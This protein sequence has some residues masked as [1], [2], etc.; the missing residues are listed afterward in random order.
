MAPRE[1]MDD[2]MDDSEPIPGAVPLPASEPAFSFTVE[3]PPNVPPIAHAAIPNHDSENNCPS[4]NNSQPSVDPPAGGNFDDDEHDARLV[5]L[6]L[7]VSTLEEKID[8]LHALLTNGKHH[9]IAGHQRN[10]S[11]SKAQHDDE[12]EEFDLGTMEEGDNPFGLP[13]EW[14]DLFHVQSHLQLACVIF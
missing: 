1:D 7:Q 14:M 6:S 8:D 12:G 11:K 3:S 2:D 13:P 9:N 4:S 5:D 10:L